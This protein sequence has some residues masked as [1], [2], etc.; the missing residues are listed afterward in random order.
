MSSQTPNT[1]KKKVQYYQD[2]RSI[3]F[4]QIHEIIF[5]VTLFGN[6]PYFL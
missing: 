4:I 2:P 5:P 6:F 1:E 3:N